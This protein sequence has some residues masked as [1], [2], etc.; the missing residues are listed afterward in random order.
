MFLPIVFK[1]DRDYELTWSGNAWRDRAGHPWV[2]A[3]DGTLTN[4][5][6]GGVRFGNWHVMEEKEA[7]LLEERRNAN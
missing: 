3:K 7:R 5:R 1:L 6:H 4:N 2:M